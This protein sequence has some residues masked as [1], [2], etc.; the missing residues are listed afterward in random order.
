MPPVVRLPV[1]SSG[2]TATVRPSPYTFAAFRPVHQS[3][4]CT[5]PD[6]PP[7]PSVGFPPVG[8][9]VARLARAPRSCAPCR[10]PCGVSRRPATSEGRQRLGPSV[11]LVAAGPVAAG[12]VAVSC[13]LRRVPPSGS[14]ARTSGNSP[15]I[16]ANVPAVGRP[17]TSEGRQRLAACPASGQPSA[18]GA[19]RSCAPCRSPCRVSRRPA[20]GANVPHY[21]AA[22]HGERMRCACRPWVIL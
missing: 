19:L 18:R 6:V 10:S 15:P 3:S 12:P 1:R 14:M 4:P 20:H 9:H 22:D 11:R 16:A 7:L 13:A 2:S 17:A 8:R 21:L 5:S